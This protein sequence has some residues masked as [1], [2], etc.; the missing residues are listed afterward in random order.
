MVKDRKGWKGRE[1]RKGRKG[2][3]KG[4]RRGMSTQPSG[5]SLPQRFSAVSK[6]VWHQELV[7]YVLLLTSCM[8]LAPSLTYLGFPFFRW[9]VWLLRVSNSMTKFQ[10]SMTLKFRKHT[11]AISPIHEVISWPVKNKLYTY[12]HGSLFYLL[13]YLYLKYIYF[14]NQ[15]QD[16]APSRQVLIPPSYIPSKHSSSKSYELM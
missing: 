13:A 14:Q 2:E 12:K 15:T 1:E 4:R 6:D 11:C 9:G 7:K 5:L 3:T 10:D 16:V 8:T